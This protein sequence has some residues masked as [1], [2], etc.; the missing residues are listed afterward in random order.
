MNHPKSITIH[1]VGPFPGQTPSVVRQYWVK[2]NL[3]ASAHYVIKDDECIQCIPDGE[4]AWHCGCKGNYESFGIE[5][6]PM[7]IEG[8]FSQESIDTLKQVVS[9]LAPTKILRHYDWTGKD[10]PL[11]YTP[12]SDGGDDRWRDLVAELLSKE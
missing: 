11:Y 7:N 6:I 2:N 8:R 5:V 12:L 4:V 10:C 1:W 3:Q 9:H